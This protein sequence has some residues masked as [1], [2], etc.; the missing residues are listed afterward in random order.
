M[1]ITPYITQGERSGPSSLDRLRGATNPLERFF[2]GEQI[3]L[4]DPLATARHPVP[5]FDYKVQTLGARFVSGQFMDLERSPEKIKAEAQRA[6]FPGFDHIDVRTREEFPDSRSVE[7]LL[8]PTFR[9]RL[10]AVREGA[11]PMK[12][13]RAHSLARSHQHPP[14]AKL[15]AAGYLG[16]L[17]AQEV[18]WWKQLVH[19]LPT[20]LGSG[21][22]WWAGILLVLAQVKRLR[23]I[24]GL[25]G[26]FA[27]VSGFVA[28]AFL[29]FHPLIEGSSLLVL[30]G[31][32]RQEDP[33]F[34]QGRIARISEL[35]SND[36]SQELRR[37]EEDPQT[38]APVI[39]KGF[40][41][42]KNSDVRAATRRVLSRLLTDTSISSGVFQ[43][44]VQN[45]HEALSDLM[46]LH[47]ERQKAEDWASEDYYPERIEGVKMLGESL[48]HHPDEERLLERLVQFLGDLRLEVKDEA[49]KEIARLLSL[50]GRPIEVA[51]RTMEF[52][53]ALIQAVIREEPF[54]HPPGFPL[55]YLLN[56]GKGRVQELG[57]QLLLHGWNQETERQWT[58]AGH[59]PM[60]PLILNAAF[61]VASAQ[62]GHA[63]AVAGRLL[64]TLMEFNV[65]DWS[66]ALGR[67]ERKNFL[68][69]SDVTEALWTYL[70]SIE[71]VS[72]LRQVAGWLSQHG[73]KYLSE[74]RYAYPQQWAEYLEYLPQ[75]LFADLEDT[76]VQKLALGRNPLAAL[77]LYERLDKLLSPG[78]VDD[79]QRIKGLIAAI[80]E[81]TH[82]GNRFVLRQLWDT[83]FREDAEAAFQQTL[84][85][86]KRTD[87]MGDLLPFPSN[88]NER[89]YRIRTASVALFPLGI[90]GELIPLG[91]SW[92][93]P[94]LVW[95]MNGVWLGVLVVLRI[96]WRLRSPGT[97]PMRGLMGLGMERRVFPYLTTDELRSLRLSPW[98]KPMGGS[99]N[100]LARTGTQVHVPFGGFWLDHPLPSLETR[101]RQGES[102]NDLLAKGT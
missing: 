89:G 69:R 84:K 85:W 61:A 43:Q 38:V 79:P 90:G 15:H 25:L 70:S 87:L 58:S 95:G 47:L 64:F 81:I 71:S 12:R 40:F 18:G 24:P 29:V 34:T 65:L 56:R 35:S 45:V 52:I 92:M 59:P 46:T 33:D 49:F 28:E 55:E 13:S 37:W 99:I 3:S 51:A 75:P 54:E 82:P 6:R 50:P 77:T 31:M 63:R 57:L 60:F 11:D 98:A 93:T 102:V 2:L 68:R 53:A 10:E 97:S 72:R 21:F 4:K 17:Y 14:L 7:L 88:F 1:V 101:L 83:P 80:G 48:A 27:V 20:G 23:V 74:K 96:I 76:E 5:G 22:L 62:D 19:L 66:E 41:L 8:N 67:D 78:E 16:W 32:D 30:L 39:L 94:F 91:T 100:D 9:L 36:V 42:H 86:R 26:V 44:F 73:R